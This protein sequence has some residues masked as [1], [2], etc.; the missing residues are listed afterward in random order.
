MNTLRMVRRATGLVAAL[1]LVPAVSLPAQRASSQAASTSAPR[2]LML[3]GDALLAVRNRVRSNDPLYRGAIQRLT[4]DADKALV[5][6]WDA[7]TDKHTSMPP[8]GNPHDYFSLSPYWWPDPAKANGLPYIRRDGETNPESKKDLDQPRIA[9]MGD[10]VETLALAWW[11]TGKD[12]YA[13]RAAMQLRRWFLDSATYMTPHLRYSQLIRGDEKSRRSGVID[14]RDLLNVIDAVVLLA[15]SKSWTA[16]D[17]QAIRAWFGAYSSWLRTDP[18]G[19]DEGN[20]R[21]NHGSWYA[22]Q[23]AA[24][25]LFAGDTAAA[26]ATVSG[27][28]DRI[29]WQIQADGKQPEELSRTKSYHYSNFNIDALSK[30]AELGRWVDVDLWS[31]RSADGGSLVAAIDR[32]APFVD[33]QQEWPDKEISNEPAGLLFATFRRA[34]AALNDAKYDA[35]IARIGDAAPPNDRAM[36]MYPSIATKSSAPTPTPAASQGLGAHPRIFLN[37][38]DAAAL[39][40]NATRYPLLNKSINEAKA[41]VAKAMLL[42][43]E[44]PTP[45][46]AGGY[47]H[48][49]HK[50]NY[51]D[52]Q[53]A[54]ALYAITGNIRYATWVRDVLEAY[55]KLYPTLGAHPL[56]KNQAPGKLFHQSLNEANWLVGVSLAYDCVY[57]ALTPAERARYEANVLRPMAD[58]MSV[59]QSKEFDRIHNHGT[60]A[61]AAVGMLGLVIG[62]TTYV[63]RALYGTKGDK[64]GGFL[65]Q[66][67]ML[68]SPDGYYMEGPYYVR[69]ALLP[70]YQFAE[71]VERVRPDIRIYAYRDSILRKALF[72]AVQTAYPN[73]VFPPIN[74]AS[75]TMAIDAPETVVALDLAYARYGG[76]ERLLGGA[77]IQDRVVLNAAGLRVARDLAALKSAPSMNF[78]SVEFTD[79]FDGTRGGLGILR[80]GSGRDATMLLMKYGVHGEGHGHFDKLHFT[81]FTDGREVVPDYGF[82]RWIN[83]EPKFG[84]RY[85]P[86][87]DTYAMQT[88]AHN[89][90]VVDER[91]QNDANED[92]DEKVWPERHFFDA[93]ESSVQAMSARTDKI[94]AGVGMQRTMLLVRDERLPYPVVVDLFRLRSGTPHTYDWPIHYRGQLISTNV[95]Y[96]A[97]TKALTSLGTSFGYQHLWREA[98]GTTDTGVQFTWL[99]GSRY[100]SITSSASVGTQV[101][102]A[103]TGAGDPNF[104]LVSEP[105]MLLRR[106]AS[107]HLFAS[108]IEPHGMFSEPQERS[109]QARPRISAVRVLAS[110][111]QGSV[112][113]VSGDNGILWT[114]MVT[115]ETASRTATHRIV[116]NGMNYDWTGNFAVRGVAEHR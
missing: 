72:T 94:Y 83:I 86:E 82:S 97:A 79:G 30:L 113:E 58:W 103:R 19:R 100:Y 108:V 78:G 91:T 24:Y 99:D 45:G 56:A 62:D 16:K 76:D 102:L 42:P 32:L 44:A 3:R 90:V 89:T 65:K 115:N 75:R 106:R 22:T 112:V 95:K 10:R 53:S 67:D 17:D 27:V 31:F 13:E 39:A 104:N 48:E 21:N 49:K 50:Q 52:M 33:R 5:A 98:A 36:L 29:N 110:T 70:F 63:N 18:V 7:V 14:G 69:Y 41:D 111:E 116:A 34:R 57:N 88:I 66:L 6:P 87:N 84:G 71:A 114:I 28:R 109:V 51:R 54:G 1:W 60:W 23:V 20:A 11:Y 92:V 47:A 93:S 15:Q 26:R 37:K 35:V 81:L 101:I 61:A 38:A 73:G 85:L 107:D 68:F 4:S 40:A 64:S 25:A 105:M 74:D 80:S 77:V 12:A 2:T 55:A 43:I 8:S 59:T 9:R 96:E 46:E